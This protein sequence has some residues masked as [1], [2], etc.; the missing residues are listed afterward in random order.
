MLLPPGGEA[1]EQAELVLSDLVEGHLMLIFTA[2]LSKRA[3]SLVYPLVAVDLGAALWL[4]LLWAVAI[5]TAT[6]SSSPVT[7]ATAT[8]VMRMVMVAARGACY[9]G[10]G[11][12]AGDS[13]RRHGGLKMS[14]CR[15][16]RC[17]DGVDARLERK[18]LLA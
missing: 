8:M 18:N 16:G 2:L 7:A 13:Y 9:C 14:R 17:D 1:V 6:S 10:S 4:L 12:Q 15:R 3:D 11:T 5:V